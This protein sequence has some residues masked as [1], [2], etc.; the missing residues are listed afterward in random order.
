MPVFFIWG[1]S[2]MCSFRD[3]ESKIDVHAKFF[4]LKLLHNVWPNAQSLWDFR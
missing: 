1:N 3:W 4:C 2:R